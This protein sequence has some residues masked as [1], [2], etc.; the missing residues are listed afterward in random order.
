MLI[1]DSE[2]IT[3]V[4]I[5]TIKN[6]NNIECETED[7]Q[8]VKLH[9]TKTQKSDSLFWWTLF[10]IRAAELWIPIQTATQTLLAFDWLSEP[11]L[12]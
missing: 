6:A 3:T 10:K 12:N 4:Q 5:K 7:G 9:L 1:N 2:Q 8:T 11:V